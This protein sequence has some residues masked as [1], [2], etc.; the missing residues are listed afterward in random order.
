MNFEEYKNIYFG[1]DEDDAMKAFVCE[2][3]QENYIYSHKKKNWKEMASALTTE[4]RRK[5][6]HYLA[7]ELRRK[8]GKKKIINI[9]E[10]ENYVLTVSYLKKRYRSFHRLSNV[11]GYILLFMGLLFFVSIEKFEDFMDFRRWLI[12]LWPIGGFLMIFPKIRFLHAL[13]KGNFHIEKQVLVKK[14]FSEGDAESAGMYTLVFADGKIFRWSDSTTTD[15]IAIKKGEPGYLVVF[16]GKIKLAFSAKK[17]KV[18]E[19]DFEYDDNKWKVK[20]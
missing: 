14:Q 8:K 7:E 16:N 6:T 20:A 3:I 2:R 18:S 12:M 19:S 13:N 15:A 9:D 10:E 17:Y 1:G 5:Y 4:Q 11:F